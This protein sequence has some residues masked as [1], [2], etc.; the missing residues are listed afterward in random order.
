MK[1]S[2]ISHKIIILLLII[3][4]AILLFKDI[5]KEEANF[6][7]TTSMINNATDTIAT[8]SNAIEESKNNDNFVQN[9]DPIIERQNISDNMATLE[10]FKLEIDDMD[11]WKDYLVN[12]VI[13]NPELICK[14]IL[15]N[16]DSEEHIYY[17]FIDKLERLQEQYSQYKESIPF[18]G[19]KI[20]DYTYTIILLFNECSKVSYPIHK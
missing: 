4:I 3:V 9:K 7:N 10:S 8:S 17:L 5:N 6:F 18:I 15:Q 13:N 2:E 1:I 16:K 20:Q 11:T 14:D 19:S 12:K